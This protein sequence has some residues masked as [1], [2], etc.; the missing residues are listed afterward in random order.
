MRRV[1][2]ILSVLCYVA[3]AFAQ[4]VEVSGTVADTDNKALSD[5]IVKVTDGTKTYAFT[6]TDSKGSYGITLDK[7][8]TAGKNLLLIFTHISFVK[9]T[10]ALAQDKPKLRHDIVMIAKNV[11]LTEVKVHA[12]PLHMAGDTLKY[13]LASFIGKGD[14]TLE[15][16]LKR[17]PGIEVS[18]DGAISY[19]GKGISKFYIEGLDMLG[20]KY[21]L[22]T[23][24]IPA[25]YATQVEV[26]RHHKERKVDVNTESDDVAINIRLSKKAKFKPFGQP[27]VGLG[28]REEDILAA[29]GLTG[30]MFN[31]RFQLLGSAKFGNEGDY[32]KYDIIDHYDGRNSESVAAGLL[33]NWSGGAPPIGEYQ[34]QRTGYGSI[35]S[36]IK[37]GENRTFRANAEYSY[38]RYHNEYSTQTLYFA[39]GQNISISES[40]H[41]FAHAHRPSLNLRY[42]DNADKHYI[43]DQLKVTASF[44]DADNPVLFNGSGFSQHRDAKSFYIN[45]LFNTTVNKDNTKYNLLSNV[46]Y[47]RAPEVMLRMNDVVQKAQSTSVKTIHST[48]VTLN[49]N[50]RWRIEMPLHLNADYDFLKS[51]LAGTLALDNIQGLKG[52]RIVPSATP[53]TEWNSKRKKAHARLRLGVK[54]NNMHYSSI[55]GKKA[56]TDYSRL[57]FE[58]DA[59]FRYIFSGGTSEMTAS[60]G[61]SHK[62]GDMTDLLTTPIQTDYRNTIMASGII[63]ETKTWHSSL[64]YKYQIPFSFFAM[65][66]HAGWTQGKQNVLSSQRVDETSINVENIAKD[67][68]MR[69]ANAGITLSKNYIPINTKLEGSLSGQWGSRESMT[70]NTPVTVYSKGYSV[71]GRAMCSPTTWTEIT[72]RVTYGENYTRFK[73]NNNAYDDLSVT[74]TWAIYPVKP[75]EIKATYDYVHTQISESQHK[76]ASLLHASA[77]YKAKR[78]NWKL[79]LNNILNTKH[80]TY[81][82]FTGPDRYIFDCSLMGRTLMLI[83]T[84]NLVNK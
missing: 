68:Y 4:K 49:A 39:D 47:N 6:T 27:E 81:T 65:N 78:A 26:L 35:N 34:N 17:L 43:N 8:I 30:M 9:E 54:W 16:G 70:Q 57:Q 61:L 12:Q 3:L 23:K 84:F 62:T 80:Y 51:E 55:Y 74:G 71:S 22:A 13:N 76:D 11:E 44:E 7:K 73:G 60:S 21:N 67:S 46:S 20:G 59:H 53:S 79:S 41:P 48:S 2:M 36:I 50:G 42:V 24:N 32:G 52:W 25:Q 10:I 45:N 5:V 72:A 75:L 64:N 83:C 29:L 69:S 37:N 63:G 18:K 14:V 40:Q 33:Q 58:P 19:L 15:D 38:E 28:Y 31:D 82:T 77:Q 66:V 56:E 1:L